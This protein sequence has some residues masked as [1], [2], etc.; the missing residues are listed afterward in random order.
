[1]KEREEVKAGGGKRGRQM[2]GQPARQ[3]S[4]SQLRQRIIPKVAMLFAITNLS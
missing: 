4:D 3:V 2:V 1:M